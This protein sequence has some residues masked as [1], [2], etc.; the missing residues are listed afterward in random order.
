MGP[1]TEECLIRRATPMCWV[2]A[3]G[4]SSSGD[5]EKAEQATRAAFELPAANGSCGPPQSVSRT[6]E[7]TSS[8]APPQRHCRAA[9]YLNTGMQLTALRAVADADRCGRDHSTHPP[10]LRE[11]ARPA[12]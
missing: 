9:A 12:W 11:P 8:I 3:L 4:K 7:C 10:I 6:T 2:T 1:R 5:D